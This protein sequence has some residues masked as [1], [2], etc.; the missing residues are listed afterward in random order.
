MAFYGL[1]RLRLLYLWRKEKKISRDTSQNFFSCEKLKKVTVQLPIYNERFVVKRLIDS[2]C[3]LHWPRELLEIQVLDDSDDKTRFIVDRQVEKWQKRGVNIYL[4]RRRERTGYKAG[5]L[6]YGLKKATG[7]FIA[8]FDADFLPPRDF[9]KKTM[10]Y[11][12]DTRV[13]FVQSRWGFLNEEHSWFTRLQAV[14]L[15]A[16]FGVEQ[17]L[18]FRKGF[19]LNFNGTAGIWRKEAIVSAGGWQA[20]TVTEDLD[21]SFRAQLKGWRAVYLDDLEVPSELPITLAALRN[22]QRRWAKGSIQT[23]R[24]IL[25]FLWRSKA[26]LAQKIEGTIHLLSNLGW[27]MGSLIFLTLYPALLQRVGIGLYQIL[28][29]DFPLFVLA[30]GAFL[31]YFYFHERYGRRQSA[32]KLLKNFVLLPAFG[33]GLAPAVALGVLEGLFSYGGEFVRTPKFGL[34]TSKRLWKKIR[35]YHRVSW[36]N[37][38]IDLG[39]FIYSLFPIIFALKRG[40]LL[41]LPFLAIFSLG[42]LLMLYLDLFDLLSH[43][44]IPPSKFLTG[45]RS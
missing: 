34:T 21:L 25:P 19:F 22:Q 6:A 44:S 1:Y 43:S 11:F 35:G 3:Q 20:D 4:L 39:F 2:V 27:L 8:I 42:F 10:P 16:H 31:C 12:Q 36:F 32:P 17:F 13:G 30:T 41:A 5:A 18:R 38:V 26:T 40:T 14:F 45:P 33:L 23:A 15:S 9:L 28:R 24:K 29:V 7:D 37:F